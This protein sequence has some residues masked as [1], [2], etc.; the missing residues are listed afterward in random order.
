MKA[1]F[2]EEIEKK[3]AWRAK[4]YCPR[5][6]YSAYLV[7][8][9]LQPYTKQPWWISCPYCNY[10]SAATSTREEAIERWRHENEM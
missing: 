8:N 7:H 1:T 4:M 10:E 5:C 9:Q 6:D 2:I 3:Y